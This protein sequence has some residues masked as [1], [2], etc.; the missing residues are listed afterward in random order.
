M[1]LT[2]K[3]MILFDPDQYKQLQEI[4][5]REHISVGQIIRKAVEEMVL[6]KTTEEERIDAAKRLTSAK[7]EFVD[8]EKIEETIA[9]AHIR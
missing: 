2:K 6:K 3:A 8:W 1:P 9:K 7:E 5:M 4:S